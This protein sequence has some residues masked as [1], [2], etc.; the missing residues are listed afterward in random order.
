KLHEEFIRG[1]ATEILQDL[2]GVEVKGECC[3]LI[4]GGSEDA[5]ITD[6]AWWMHLTIQE[7]VDYYETEKEVPH[8]KALKKVAVYRNVT[9]REKY[10][11]IHVKKNGLGM[12]KKLAF[13][14]RKQAWIVYS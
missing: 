7:H 12:S 8:K 2:Q 1:T 10:E 11:T 6:T 5:G 3:I 13:E 14:I 9:R 4:E